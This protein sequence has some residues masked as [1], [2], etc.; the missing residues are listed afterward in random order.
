MSIT[1]S[2]IKTKIRPYFLRFVEPEI[3]EFIT[4][5]DIADVC[6]FVADQ[7]NEAAHINVERYYR[8]TVI[9]QNDY[10]MNG[11]IIKII[12]LKY[13]SGDFTT[14]KYTVVP[15]AYAEGDDNEG[16][17]Y[18][19]I[20]FKITPTSAN[21]QLDILYLRRC[22]KILPT[23]DTDQLDLPDKVIPDFLEL[24]KT[25]IRVDYGNADPLIW[26]RDLQIKCN[27]IIGKLDNP[28][29][30]KGRVRNY[31]GVM[32]TKDDNFYDI[33][34]KRLSEDHVYTDVNGNFYWYE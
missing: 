12:Y 2:E 19:V 13:E 27:S 29:I 8:K 11:D 25:K 10:E 31:W 9:D 28:D 1:W 34:D 24:L 18:S 20:V 30:K 26:D 3:I 7:M 5:S 32:D 16:E 21:I 15:V 4:D 33:V 14:Q 23:A 22:H 17:F 6:N